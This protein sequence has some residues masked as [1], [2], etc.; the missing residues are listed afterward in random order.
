MYQFLYVGL[1]HCD[2]AFASSKMAKTITAHREKNETTISLIGASA[3][4]L[5]EG[6]HHTNF[7]PRQGVARKHWEK[8]RPPFHSLPFYS[9]YLSLPHINDKT[10]I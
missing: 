6:K 1:T 3:G 9:T 4:K 5:C 7:V 10:N 8:R 2:H